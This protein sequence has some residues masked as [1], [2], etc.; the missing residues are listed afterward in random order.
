MLELI[1]AVIEKAPFDSLVVV[2]AD[3]RF[4]FELLPGQWDVRT[5]APAAVGVWHKHPE[6]MDA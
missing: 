1:A 4:D 3:E 6:I 5:Y 2:E